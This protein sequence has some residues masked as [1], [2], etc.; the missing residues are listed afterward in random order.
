MAIVLDYGKHMIGRPPERLLIRLATELGE[1]RQCFAPEDSSLSGVCDFEI[2]EWEKQINLLDCMGA[3]LPTG[4]AFP[5]LCYA[6]SAFA[7]GFVGSFTS[8]RIAAA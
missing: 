6:H 8:A 2:H 4:L 1:P 3:H 5:L 7:F